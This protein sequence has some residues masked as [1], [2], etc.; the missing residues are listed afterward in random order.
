MTL[1]SAIIAQGQLLETMSN[2]SSRWLQL[3]KRLR[4][5]GPKPF[6][7]SEIELMEV[8]QVNL[9]TEEK[10]CR[11]WLGLCMYCR[12]KGHCQAPCMLGP[13]NKGP[14][15]PM[16]ECRCITL[17]VRLSWCSEFCYF[18]AL[19]DSRAVGNFMDED[20]SKLLNV[21]LIPLTDPVTARLLMAHH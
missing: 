14:V 10:A 2:S 19:I 9:T 13:E 5:V 7:M 16:I 18:P 21:P 3:W 1:C 12:N 15:Q 20:M 6:F 4:M 17:A 8:A 11:R